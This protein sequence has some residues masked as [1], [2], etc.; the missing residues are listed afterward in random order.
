MGRWEGENAP[1]EGLRLA[2][3]LWPEVVLA[4]VRRLQLP[5][6]L[7]TDLPLPRVQVQGGEAV[8]AR[9]EVCN[10]VGGWWVRG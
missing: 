2:R 6:P 4:L 10:V 8:L 9:E 5:Q 1:L 3:D 7:C